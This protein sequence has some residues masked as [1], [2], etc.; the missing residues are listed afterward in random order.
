MLVR[1]YRDSDLESV[2]DLHSRQGLPYEL[3]PLEDMM[4]S[5]LIEEG[6]NVTHAVFLRMTAETYWLFDGNR[7]WKRQTLGRLLVLHKELQPIAAIS[8]LKDIHAFIPPTILTTKTENTMMTLGWKKALWP[9][10]SRDVA[11]VLV[12]K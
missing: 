2:L 5:C 1:P 10:F 7:E 8:G 6:G 4:A 12:E 9:C 3:P 11:P